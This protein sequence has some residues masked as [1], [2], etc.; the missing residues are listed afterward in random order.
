MYQL[1]FQFSSC[2]WIF[3]HQT[4]NDKSMDAEKRT[5]NF[6]SAKKSLQNLNQG[7]KIPVAYEARV[8]SSGSGFSTEKVVER[9]GRCK[10]RK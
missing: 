5:H 7:S 1:G 4:L 2:L 8:K 6:L 10:D 9:K 3:Y